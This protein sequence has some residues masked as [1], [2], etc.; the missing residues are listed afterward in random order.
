MSGACNQ[1]S[2]RDEPVKLYLSSFLIGNESHRLA[3]LT[4]RKR[5]VVIANALDNVSGDRQVRVDGEIA[6]LKKLGFDAEELDLRRYF[7]TPDRLTDDLQDVGLIWATGGNV[8]LLRRH[9]TLGQISPAV[10]ECRAMAQAALLNRPRDRLKL[11]SATSSCQNLDGR[12][13]RRRFSAWHCRLRER[14]AA[15]IVFSSRVTRTTSCRS[16]RSRR[17]AASLRTSSADQNS[18][19]RNAATG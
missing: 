14:N 16:G 2:Y 18:K 4:D 6:E 5:A 15:S 11:R 19:S 13:T 17:T 8:F 9:S 10:F 3:S 1:L 12:A 7:K